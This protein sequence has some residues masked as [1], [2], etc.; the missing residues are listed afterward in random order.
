MK[1]IWGLGWMWIWTN[2]Q[3]CP[4]EYDTIRCDGVY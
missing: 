2:K 1:A 3:H 4:A